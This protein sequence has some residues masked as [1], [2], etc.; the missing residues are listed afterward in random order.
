MN[1]ETKIAELLVRDNEVRSEFYVMLAERCMTGLMPVV[2]SAF[3]KCL[4]R[5]VPI[6]PKIVICVNEWN[7]PEGKVGRY[8]MP[9]TERDYGVMTINPGAFDGSKASYWY[10]IA[11]ELIH[12]LL[13]PES[14]PHNDDFEAIATELDI[15]ERYRD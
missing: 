14:D 8:E 3:E 15:P 9:N 4:H 12:A 5:E 11:H 7:L 10:V 6:L 2:C 1:R 13:G